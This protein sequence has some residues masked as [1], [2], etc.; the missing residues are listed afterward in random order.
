MSRF[1]RAPFLKLREDIELIFKVPKSFTWILPGIGF[2]AKIN[3]QFFDNKPRKSQ[4]LRLKLLIFCAKLSQRRIRIFYKI[5]ETASR[6]N[7]K[8]QNQLTVASVLFYTLLYKALQFIS[9]R[10]S[11]FSP[12]ICFIMQN[13]YCKQSRRSANPRG[14]CFRD[15]KIHT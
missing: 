12:E 9:L 7:L 14:S 6:M 8:F 3:V 10:K 15:R 5:Q 13:A 2:K 1:P 4:K 11:T